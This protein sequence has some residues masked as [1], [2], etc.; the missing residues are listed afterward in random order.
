MQWGLPLGV[1]L[2][3]LA[4]APAVRAAVPPD[5]EDVGAAADDDATEPLL[6]IFPPRDAAPLDAFLAAQAD[7][8]APGYRRWLTPAEFGDRFGV[9]AADYE[10]AARWLR[11]RGFAGVQTWPGRLAIAF[12]GTAGQVA[13]AFKTRMRAYRWQGARRMAPERAAALPAFGAARPALLGLDGFVR[14]HPGVRI[15][16]ADRLGPGDLYV[17]HGVGQVHGDGITG[18]GVTIAVLAVSDFATSDVALFRSTFG[19]TPGTVTKRFAG[20]NPGS[21]DV[22]ALG[23]VLLDT[24]WS[25]AIA[26]GATLVAEIAASA[27]AAAFAAAGLDVINNDVADVLSVS[28]GVC[29][30]IATSLVAQVVADMSRQAAA[31][32]MSVLVSSGDDGVADCRRSNGSLAP[33]V[34]VFAA[35]PYVTAVGGTQLDPLFDAAGDATGYGGET[36]WN[37]TAA[38][39]GGAG[40]G[41]RSVFFGKPSYQNLPGLPADGARDVPDVAFAASPGHPGFALVGGGIVLPFGVGGTSASAPV[42]AGMAALLV[43]KRGGRLG[44]L[45]GELYQLGLEQALGLRAPVFHDVTAGN[46]GLPGVPGPAAGPGY[47]LATGWG[48]FD[49]PA[50][51]A[52]FDPGPPCRDDGDCDD[53][54]VCTEDRCTPGGC[55]HSALKDGAACRTLDC[56]PGSC[57]ASACVRTGPGGCDDQDPCTH[58]FCGSQGF[59]GQSAT[60]GADAL[61]CV[62]AGGEVAAPECAGER[63]PRALGRSVARAKRLL[64][65]TY[66]RN[67]A[68]LRLIDRAGRQLAKAGRILAHGAKKLTPSC[69]A[70]LQEQVDGALAQLAHLRGLLAP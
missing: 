30:P 66:G 49:A 17:A 3:V 50:L 65:H 59:C 5:A 12:Q 2:A 52:A 57:T 67:R 68:T 33:A 18:Q 40:G 21:G 53:R 63:V 43:Q 70:S 55:R 46:V 28:F 23:E 60:I 44:L 16:T 14:V 32:G 39:G 34:N 25:G 8:H 47:D 7:P 15:G 45:N 26:P 38:S 11:R 9:G 31:L 51:L 41:G 24:E 42:W 69:R 64:G 62:F 36:V 4:G 22:L 1:L 29:E 19:V 6:L 54:N 61:S 35:S 37:D 10:A 48:S 13:R 20:A 56:A 58:D 27:N